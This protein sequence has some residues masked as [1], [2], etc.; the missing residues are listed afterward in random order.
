V[1]VRAPLGASARDAAFAGWYVGDLAVRSRFRRLGI[2]TRLTVAAVEY[3]RARGAAS[4]RLAVR[5]ANTPARRLYEGLGFVVVYGDDVWR[6]QRDERERWGASRLAMELTL[7]A[8]G[9][10]ATK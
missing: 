7:T 10:A 9:G 8:E 6:W 4:L 2:G 3:V 5:P 1:W